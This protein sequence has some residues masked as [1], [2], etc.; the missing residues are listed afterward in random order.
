MQHVDFDV[1]SLAFDPEWSE[2]HEDE[3]KFQ[4]KKQEKQMIEALNYNVLV[5]DEETEE[6]REKAR[7]RKEKDDHNDKVLIADKERV[8]AAAARSH[9]QLSWDD[10][11]GRHYWMMAVNHAA[12]LKML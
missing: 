6:L 4:L 8:A 12:D 11:R 10:V 3:K 1:E 2:A 5:S 7:L 9:V